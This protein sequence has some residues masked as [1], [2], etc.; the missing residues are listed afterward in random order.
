M[1]LR[2]LTVVGGRGGGGIRLGGEIGNIYTFSSH[3]YRPNGRD[4]NSASEAPRK[5][6][7]PWD[8]CERWQE[9]VMNLHLPKIMSQFPNG[10][11]AADPALLNRSQCSFYDTTYFR[12]NWV[13]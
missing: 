2:K 6:P 3:Y 5:C 13:V 11:R 1:F 12:L 10:G 4:G 7:S 9:F 8:R